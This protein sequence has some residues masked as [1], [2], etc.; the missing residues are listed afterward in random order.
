MAAGGG[1]AARV[2]LPERDQQRADSVVGQGLV[3]QEG[4]LFCPSALQ[5]GDELHD[6]QSGVEMDVEHRQPDDAAVAIAQL[7]EDRRQQRLAARQPPRKRLDKRP[8]Q[9]DARQGR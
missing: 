2:G 5:A 3:Q 6:P 4:N 8:F 7:G 1:S 9:I